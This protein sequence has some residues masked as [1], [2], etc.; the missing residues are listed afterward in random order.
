MPEFLHRGPGWKHAE[1]VRNK[2]DCQGADRPQAHQ[3][4]LAHQVVAD[5]DLFFV[6]VSRLIDLVVAFGLKEEMTRLPAGHRDAPGQQR[7]VGG[8]HEQKGIGRDKA[9]CAEQMQALIDSAMMVIAVIVPAK[10][11]ERFKKLFHV[12][13]IKK[14]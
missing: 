4:D 6:F 2:P 3:N 13:T 14:M 9:Q 5:L 10:N 12:G 7:C 11:G 1:E 8:V